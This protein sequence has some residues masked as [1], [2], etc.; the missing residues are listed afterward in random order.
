MNWE[1][2]L[3]LIPY[4]IALGIS[5]SVG[6]YAW[7]RRSLSSALS[8]AFFTLAEGGYTAAYVFEV[9]SPGVDTKVFWDNLQLLAIYVAPL[10][11][12][13]F[14]V[15]YTNVQIPR[16][17]QFW[18]VVSSVPLIGMILA[19]TDALHGW[20]RTDIRIKPGDPFEQL[21]YT[22]TPLFLFFSIYAYAFA[23]AACVLLA[24]QLLRTRVIY[25]S[26]V[27]T[28]LIGL[29]MP[30]IGAALVMSRTAHFFYL[31]VMPLSFVLSNVIV[32]WGLFRY[33]L[34][35]VLP[36][37]QTTI[38]S[39][40]RDAVLVLDLRNRLLDF[41]PAAQAFVPVDL[42]QVLGQPA[43]DIFGDW[44]AL[45]N[46]Y[47]DFSQDV[48]FEITGRNSENLRYFEVRLSPVVDV[49]EKAVG[50]L[51]T[52]RDITVRKQVD[53]E[54]RAY[55]ETLEEKIAERTAALTAEIVERE[56]AQQALAI[57]E[58]RYRRATHAGKV[59]VWE[60]DVARRTLHVASELAISLGYDPK[61][62][63]LTP[64]AWRE[65]IHPDDLPLL[66]AELLVL[67]RGQRDQFVADVRVLDKGGSIHWMAMRGS[68][69]YGLE[70]TVQ[71]LFGTA[72]DVTD[73]MLTQRALQRRDAILQA[74]NSVAE[75]LL[76]SADWSAEIEAI[77]AALGTATGVDRA[78]LY[79]AVSDDE[80][81]MHGDL[82]AVWSASGVMDQC[83][84]PV[85]QQIPLSDPEFESLVEGWS[86]GQPLAGEIDDLPDVVQQRAK[87]WGVQSVLCVPVVVR[88][89]LWGLFSLHA[90]CERREW[91][92]AEIEALQTA[93]NIFGTAVDRQLANEN[94]QQYANRLRVL[95]EIDKQILA[96]QSTQAV[97]ES[98]LAA[99][100]QLVP[101]VWASVT[102][103]DLEA[104]TATILTSENGADVHVTVGETIPLDRFEKEQLQRGGVW[105]MGDVAVYDGA[106]EISLAMQAMII[107][108][109][110]SLINVPLRYEGT[111]IGTLSM[112][113]N[114]PHHFGV[115]DVDAVQQV[116]A[117]LAIV[118][119]Q[120]HLHE[121]VRAY[122]EELEQ[123]VTERTTELVEA[124]KHLR[125]LTLLKDEFVSNVSHELRTPIS[126]LKLYLELL[127]MRPERAK[128][129]GEVLARETRRLETLIED[130]LTLSR[131][132]QDR[133]ALR[134]R[135]V[136]LNQLVS[137]YVKDR[138]VMAEAQG[139]VLQ[140]TTV[141]DLP[142][143]SA[144]PGLIGQVLSILLTNAFNY[145]PEGGF[146]IVNTQ[147]IVRNDTTWVTF[148]VEDTGPGIPPD[149]HAR[150]FTRFF[151]G[152]VGRDSGASG[153]GLGLAIAKAI[154]DRHNGIIEVLST[155]RL[156]GGTVFTV[157][158]PACADEPHQEKEEG[159]SHVTAD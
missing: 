142:F 7:Q 138:A 18:L 59:G 136:D 29:L 75:R 33:R 3:Y 128:I 140:C 37:A 40:L 65:A 92:P 150:L 89:N 13:S 153:T 11:F 25:R 135:P 38:I 12:F 98:A 108:G 139:L 151:R 115:D 26:R 145:T 6:L 148:S 53:A 49:R 8:F 2:F 45:V 143:A 15:Q 46:E 100:V 126:N 93:V 97:A 157:L 94:L 28:I 71:R 63:S 76:R 129:Y 4:L 21:L 149:E 134:Q 69:V 133:V 5:L 30:I 62:L 109:I 118:V 141:P 103:F 52:V 19:F 39:N 87:C 42:K 23:L 158:L 43:T 146:V 91:Q 55:R 113:H 102:I 51:I 119:H 31:E 47:T 155:G 16:P 14:A 121:Q 24:R 44:A 54:L 56:R 20:F 120:A 132:D 48:Q 10:G 34:L 57:N 96:A 32:G 152:K 99:L 122:A 88:G 111:L 74:V 106:P 27:T 95:H 110:R 82:R 83:N 114:V 107:R 84:D 80:G 67:L 123:R 124:M 85:L 64:D 9:V 147:S 61:Y 86:G 1:A 137:E 60:W 35:D 68:A 41:N 101:C 36:I 17:R 144:D 79:Q 66:T 77:L 58:E 131:L 156:G 73:L 22:F 81:S 104:A 125:K 72:S 90:V 105:I 117:Q 159:I 154:V 116:A 50:R 112:G 130:L 127:E 70:G 78:L